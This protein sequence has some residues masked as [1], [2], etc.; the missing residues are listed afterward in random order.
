MAESAGGDARGGLSDWQI[1]LRDAGALRHQVESTPDTLTLADLA[2]RCDREERILRL[3]YRDRGD[4]PPA[5]DAGLQNPARQTTSMSGALS[6]WAYVLY[7]W[8]LENERLVKPAER[9]KDRNVVRDML[10]RQPVRVEL[11]SRVVEVT[12]RC[13]LALLEIAKHYLRLREMDALMAVLQIHETATLAKMKHAESRKRRR[14]LRQ[15]LRTFFRHHKLLLYEI[16]LQRQAMYAHAFTASGEPAE[17]LD[18]APAWWRG[19]TPEDDSLLL[20]G[21]FRVGAERSQE[22]R[23]GSQEPKEGE[24][25]EYGWH[26]LLASVERLQDLEPAT[27]YHKDL[28]QLEAWLKVLP[29]EGGSEEPKERWEQDGE[30]RKWSKA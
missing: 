25:P 14:G 28:Y 29:P 8:R 10:T 12:G 1:R 9:S 7:L 27:Y 22:L 16:P 20:R 4:F 5:W 3:Q 15:R 24:A 6:R 23:E 26:S 30:T 21:L 19:L 17:S 11:P 18:E 2:E 13:Y